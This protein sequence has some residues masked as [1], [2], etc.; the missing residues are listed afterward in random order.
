MWF[1]N[2]SKLYI[3]R[4]ITYCYIYLF[5]ILLIFYYLIDRIKLFE[6]YCRQRNHSTKHIFAF[7]FS[8]MFFK[9]TS[10]DNICLIVYL[11]VYWKLPILQL[12]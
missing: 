2:H 4:R 3:K 1:W 7:F 8:L 9:L 11:I 6:L 5:K 12:V 10:E